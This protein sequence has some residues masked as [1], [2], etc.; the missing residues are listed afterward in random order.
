MDKIIYWYDGESYNPENY[1]NFKK[2]ILQIIVFTYRKNFQPIDDYI[3]SDY[4]W[5]CMI[6]CLQMC[7]LRSLHSLFP[8]QSFIYLFDDNYDSIFSIHNLCQYKKKLNYKVD[9]W[10]GPHIATHLAKTTLIHSPLNNSFT[11]E[12]I[13]NGL[14]PKNLNINQPTILLIPLRL[15]IDALDPR[16]NSHLYILFTNSLF[17]GIITGKQNSGYYLIGIDSNLNIYYLDPHHT[18][19]INDIEYYSNTINKLPLKE[20]DP[21]MTL[22]FSLQNN[23]DLEDICEL[24]DNKDGLP[25]K[26]IDE[27]IDNNN[28]INVDEDENNDWLVLN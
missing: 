17:K 6:R 26:I 27:Y 8:L 18:Q 14:I 1:D 5:G 11:I 25:I 23:K 20:I 24:F 7:L 2:K 13:E 3:T 15:G 4:G 10:I 22:I 21:S 19:D 9:E 12:I 28:E 16:F